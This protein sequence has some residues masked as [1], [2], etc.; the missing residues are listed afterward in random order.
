MTRSMFGA[1]EFM[2][3]RRYDAMGESMD[4]CTVCLSVC[5]SVCVCLSLSCLSLCLVCLSLVSLFVFPLVVSTVLIP[6][7][8][9]VQGELLPYP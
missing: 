9:S 8:V 1:Y 2:A 6:C 7:L 5:L 3:G 4:A